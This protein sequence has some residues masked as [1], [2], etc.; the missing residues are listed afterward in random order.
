MA[1]YIMLL[2]QPVVYG[3]LL[4]DDNLIVCIFCDVI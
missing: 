1:D 3:L 4:L 2:L